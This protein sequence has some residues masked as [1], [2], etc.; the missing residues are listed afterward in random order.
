MTAFLSEFDPNEPF[1]EDR[2]R[3]FFID[4]IE[5]Q[6]KKEG[7]DVFDGFAFGGLATMFRKK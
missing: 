5:T 4:L 2:M 6:I 3:D 7:E 1:S